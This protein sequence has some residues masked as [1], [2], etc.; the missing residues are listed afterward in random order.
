MFA[1]PWGTLGKEAAYFV[2]KAA[3]WE[4]RESSRGALANSVAIGGRNPAKGRRKEREW[5]SRQEEGCE[6]SCRNEKFTKLQKL[7]LDETEGAWSLIF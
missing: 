2:E 3:Q 6:E 4:E 5:H 1:V 7:A